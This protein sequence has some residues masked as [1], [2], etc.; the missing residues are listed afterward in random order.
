[1]IGS[2]VTHSS[3]HQIGESSS[4]RSA[5]PA[6]ARTRVLGR[7]PRLLFL[8]AGGRA[9]TAGQLTFLHRS[10]G[11]RGLVHTPLSMSS[12]DER[13]RKTR[14]RHRGRIMDGEERGADGPHRILILRTLTKTV[15]GEPLNTLTEVV[16][17][18]SPRYRGQF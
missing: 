13:N 5:R 12:P 8:V 14:D 2:S 16:S 1:M 6:R 9:S 7:S 10:F 11:N 15:V 18:E 3:R 17:L 4:A